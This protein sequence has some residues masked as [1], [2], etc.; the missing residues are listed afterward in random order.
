MAIGRRYF[1]RY[2]FIKTINL[3]G[4]RYC[5]ILIILPTHLPNLIP[6]TQLERLIQALLMAP[7]KQI[8]EMFMFNLGFQLTYQQKIKL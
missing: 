1:S 7:K 3:K 6:G 4:Q 8:R 5:L 2:F